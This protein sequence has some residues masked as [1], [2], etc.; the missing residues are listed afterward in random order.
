[1][2]FIFR[3]LSSFFSAFTISLI[4]NTSFLFFDNTSEGIFNFSE[5]MLYAYLML[6]FFLL[7]GLPI[8]IFIDWYLTKKN[9]NFYRYHFLTYTLAGMALSF[10][11]PMIFGGGRVIDWLYSFCVLIGCSLVYFHYLFLLKKW[12]VFYKSV[13]LKF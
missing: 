3:I 2:T 10:V 6:P 12:F 11:L 1:M 4:T 13:P 9:K 8:S 5:V 7:I